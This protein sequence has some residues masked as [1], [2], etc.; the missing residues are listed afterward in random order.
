MLNGFVQ[1]QRCLSVGSNPILC[2]G[3]NVLKP[4][5]FGFFK[6]LF[7]FFFFFTTANKVCF[8]II[9][10]SWLLLVYM[11]VINLIC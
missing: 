5:S 2:F 6:F 8:S 3:G 4:S 9:Y 7:K 1:E 10:S 11:K